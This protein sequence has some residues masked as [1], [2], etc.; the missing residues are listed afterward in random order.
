MVIDDLIKSE[1]RINFIENGVRVV[2]YIFCDVDKKEQT[3]DA[4]IAATVKNLERCQFR[5]EYRSVV[6][7]F[8]YVCVHRRDDVQPMPQQT[9]EL[10]KHIIDQ[11]P[12]DSIYVVGLAVKSACAGNRYRV[13]FLGY[14][15]KKHNTI[16]MTRVGRAGDV[17]Y[18]IGKHK[19]LLS[20]DC[21]LILVKRLIPNFLDLCADMGCELEQPA[22]VRSV[23]DE[24][25][26]AGAEEDESVLDLRSK[27]YVRLIQPT[28][29]AADTTISWSRTIS[30]LKVCMMFMIKEWQFPGA[31]SVIAISEI[32]N[33]MNR[34]PNEF[35]AAM[36]IIAIACCSKERMRRFFRKCYCRMCMELFDSIYDSRTR[37]FCFSAN[38]VAPEDGLDSANARLE[39]E[40]GRRVD[41]VFG[42]LVERL[43]V[44]EDGFMEALNDDNAF[45]D[46]MFSVILST[47]GTVSSL[48]DV[49]ESA[50]PE[51]GSI[52]G[53]LAD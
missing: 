28:L 16:T 4:L 11:S 5:D 25:V 37:E 51:D 26:V 24:Q 7:R 41:S 36:Y 13:Y 19:Q 31:S 33:Y 22:T 30:I 45:S 43:Q 2:M 40:A 34:S 18:A 6:D 46:H 10:P 9:I 47:S 23:A 15:H 39:M 20:V 35:Q 27:D 52:F 50:E 29:L 17:R 44:S 53:Q 3:Q 14:S 42:F 1:W 48:L 49:T 12:D 21:Y 32:M 8:C 38:D